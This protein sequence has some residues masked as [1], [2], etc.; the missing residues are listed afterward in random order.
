VSCALGGVHTMLGAYSDP[1]AYY[2][3]ATASCAL[4]TASAWLP[5]CGL[6]NT[7]A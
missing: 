2:N 3:F 1:A 7:Y 4:K 6:G 5:F